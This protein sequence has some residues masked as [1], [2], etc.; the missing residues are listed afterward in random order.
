MTEEEHRMETIREIE[1]LRILADWY[2]GWATVSGREDERRN[3]L[4]LAD[5]IDA[6]ARALM[7][8]LRLVEK[9]T[10]SLSPN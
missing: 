1:R 2:R 3:R 9:P 4:G 7:R 6:K 10:S 5:H 8:G